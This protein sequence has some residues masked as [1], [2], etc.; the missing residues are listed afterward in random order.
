MGISKWVGWGNGNHAWMKGQQP[1]V[2]GIDSWHFVEY[3]FIK[4]IEVWQLEKWNFKISIVEE[5][6]CKIH[7]KLCIYNGNPMIGTINNLS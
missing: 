4:K 7:F 2:V 1:N 6:I 5:K 3:L